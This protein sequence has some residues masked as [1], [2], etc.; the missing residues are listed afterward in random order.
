MLIF[1]QHLASQAIN[2]LVCKT[3]LISTPHPDIF[4]LLWATIVYKI[5]VEERKIIQFNEP[6]EE[7]G[8]FINQKDSEI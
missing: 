8:L 5:P 1:E 6:V 2:L 4:F 7:E 3:K